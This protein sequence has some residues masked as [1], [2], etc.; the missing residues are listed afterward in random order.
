MKLASGVHRGNKD[1]MNLGKQDAMCTDL[2]EGMLIQTEM[3][4]Q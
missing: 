3:W 4:G 2:C 1:L